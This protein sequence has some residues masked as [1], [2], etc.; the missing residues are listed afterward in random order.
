MQQVYIGSPSE[1][2]VPYRCECPHSLQARSH[3]KKK[4]PDAK[5]VRKYSER[6]L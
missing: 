2:N 5:S 3:Q 1:L 4:L 6:N